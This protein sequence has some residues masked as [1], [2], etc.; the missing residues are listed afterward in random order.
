[1]TEVMKT[2]VKSIGN[3]RHE[4]SFGVADKSDGPSYN[5]YAPGVPVFERD[6]KFPETLRQVLIQSEAKLC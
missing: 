4:F 3:Q 1:M 2:Q 5:A 6:E